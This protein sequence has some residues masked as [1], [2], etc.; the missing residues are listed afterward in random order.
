[1]G[2]NADADRLYACTIPES[3]LET[4]ANSIPTPL[5]GGLLPV[6]WSLPS[7]RVTAPEDPF[8]KR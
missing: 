7:V 3:V 5:A 1:M 4:N 6:T 2:L 8:T